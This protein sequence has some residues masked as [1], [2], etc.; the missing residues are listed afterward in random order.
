[1]DRDPYPRLFAAAVRKVS[2]V[3]P[4]RREGILHVMPD[5]NFRAPG[6]EFPSTTHP[7]GPAP[8]R[9][10]VPSLHQGAAACRGKG[11]ARRSGP[12]HQ[13]DTMSHSTLQSLYR[14]GVGG[15]LAATVLAATA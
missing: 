5:R 8:Y 7:T 11:G 6:S 3:V 13:G 1:P 12:A 9:K 15:L 14:H 4:A 2:S 10:R